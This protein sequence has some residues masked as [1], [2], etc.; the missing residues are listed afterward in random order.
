M[1]HEPSPLPRSAPWGLLGNGAKTAT[2]ASAN[3][4]S[5][6]TSCHFDTFT[7]ETPLSQPTSSTLFRF[8]PKDLSAVMQWLP[9]Q[10]EL[11]HQNRDQGE[12]AR[13]WAGEDT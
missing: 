7:P 8:E 10:N 11:R 1:L 3:A 6:L 5:T 2:D 4:G 13:T 9:K 12:V